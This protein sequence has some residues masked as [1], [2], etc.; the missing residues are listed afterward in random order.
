MKRV[1]MMRITIHTHSIR[2]LAPCQETPECIWE[3]DPAPKWCDFVLVSTFSGSGLPLYLYWWSLAGGKSFVF[4]KRL[5]LEQLGIWSDN[6]SALKTHHRSKLCCSKRAAKSFVFERSRFGQVATFATGL[7]ML[8][9]VTYIHVNETSF[10]KITP[11]ETQY[12][13]LPHV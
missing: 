11:I 8:R 4:G 7:S 12:A 6:T 3:P 13:C 2:K 9:I 5:Q 1:F 10:V